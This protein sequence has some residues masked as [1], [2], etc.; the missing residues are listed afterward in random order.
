MRLDIIFP[1][2]PFVDALLFNA[3]RFVDFHGLITVENTTAI[4]YDRPGHAC[5]RE[6]SEQY[7]QIVPVILGR[8][9]FA[10]QHRAGVVF[11]DTDEV[12][13]FWKAQ[14]MLFDI[15]DIHGPVLVTKAGLKWHLFLLAGRSALRA[16][17]AK[18]TAIKCEQPTTGRL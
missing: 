13:W 2:L 4:T 12:N 5:C 18:Q 14:V 11:Q 8:R 6:G 7:L 1:C 10:G 9:D 15:S 3:Q 17:Q 16:G